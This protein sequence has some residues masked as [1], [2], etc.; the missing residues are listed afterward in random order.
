LPNAV[1]YRRSEAE[2]CWRE[3]TAP[4]LFVTGAES[5][6]LD[7]LGESAQASSYEPTFPDSRS[8]VIDGAG[9]MVH[10]EAP[11]ALARA[12]EQFLEATL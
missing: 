6:L 5:R 9:H 3:V 8:R 12:I 2:A 10:I 11:A 1:L 4:V 7:V